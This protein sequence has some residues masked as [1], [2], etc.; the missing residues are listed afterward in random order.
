MGRA[1]NEEVMPRRLARSAGAFLPLLA[2][3]GLLAAVTQAAEPARRYVAVDRSI[4]L[5]VP[6]RF[7][8]L[9]VANPAIADVIV[10]A[11]NQLVV[12]GK[13]PGTTSLVVGHPGRVESFDLVVYPAPG[14]SVKTPVVPSGARLVVVQR[15]DKI[16]NHLFVPNE[17]RGWVEL[18]TAK[19][20]PEP[21]KK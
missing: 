14:V 4:V 2:T 19:A 10:L 20:E 15:A 1:P 11:P 9:S 16:T 13:A 12:N 6:E 21:V 7:T 8:K 5:E 18:E 17:E 3:L